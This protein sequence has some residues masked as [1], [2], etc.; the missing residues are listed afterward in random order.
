MRKKVVIKNYFKRKL[1]FDNR[2]FSYTRNQGETE[3]GEDRQ[4]KDRGGRMSRSFQ[5]RTRLHMV[6]RESGR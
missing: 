6:Q 2:D 4:E 3:G 5:I 1:C